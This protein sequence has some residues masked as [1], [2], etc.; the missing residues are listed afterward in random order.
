VQVLVSGIV[1]GTV[2]A[3]LA[4]GFS[5]IWGAARIINLAYTSFYMLA[6]YF[7]YTFTSLLGIPMVLGVPL[8]VFLATLLGVS[9]YKF[10]LERIRAHD[11]VV[12][13]ISILIA[14]FF[15]EIVLAVFGQQLYSV[16]PFVEGYLELFGVRVLKQY[17]LAFGFSV[18]LL[19]GLWIF[20]SR[21]RIGIAIRAT[22]QDKEVVNLMGI[23]EKKV[24]LIAMILGTG[25]VTV[26][27][28]VV[29]P[30]YVVEPSMWMHPIIM[31]LAIVV[32]GG[33]GSLKGSVIAAYILGFSEVIVVNW[34]PMGA[35]IKSAIALLV[36]VIVL[37]IKPEGMFGVVFEEER[38]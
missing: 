1:I 8:S 18:A 36:M 38:L 30:I 2:Y 5:L 31:I 29:S 37:L 32:L 24:S 9:T 34:L 28:V 20:L 4:L 7:F 22:S 35:F 19:V 25:F 26:S 33:L 11:T 27:S 6:A 12:M 14:F 17:F 13:L 21:F 10:C 23:S 3:V 15:E 16:P